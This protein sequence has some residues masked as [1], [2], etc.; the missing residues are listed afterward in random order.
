MTHMA[1]SEAAEIYPGQ[2]QAVQTVTALSRPLNP[3][4]QRE[5]AGNVLQDLFRKAKQRRDLHCIRFMRRAMQRHFT[6]SSW[7]K[8]VRYWSK[9]G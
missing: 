4:V 9:L 3:F 8:Q 2:M 1:R 7:C 5:V 6:A